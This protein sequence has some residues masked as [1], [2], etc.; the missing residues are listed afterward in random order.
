MTEHTNPPKR[1]QQILGSIEK[2]PMLPAVAIRLLEVT[3][4]EN[5]S[6]RDLAQLIETDQA[7]AAKTLKMANSAFY[8]RSRKISTIRDAVAL[9]GFVAIRSSLLSV[10]FLDVF[11]VRDDCTGF[12]GE[13]FW[14]HSLA[15]AIC[16][17]EIGKC[18]LGPAPFAEEAF[19][20][21]MLYDAGKILLNNYMEDDYKRVMECVRTQ[22]LTIGEAERMVLEFDHAQGGRRTAEALEVSRARNTCHLPSSSPLRQSARQGSGFEAGRGHQAREYDCQNPQDRV[23][24]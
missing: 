14:L 13:A 3:E 22:N 18:S 4:D 24:R 20:C 21:G 12:D 9:I 15:C 16:C 11:K 6:A 17:R 2:L 10:F 8:G 23:R 5:S 7:L 19:V 1:I